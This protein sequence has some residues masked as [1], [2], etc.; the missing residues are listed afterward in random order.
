MCE[1][2]PFPFH[3]EDVVKIFPKYVALL[4]WQ[5]TPSVPQADLIGITNARTAQRFGSLTVSSAFFEIFVGP[6][7]LNRVRV[8]PLSELAVNQ[9]RTGS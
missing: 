7:G 8:L 4:T 2:G 1:I 3:K 6:R 5:Q 9:R